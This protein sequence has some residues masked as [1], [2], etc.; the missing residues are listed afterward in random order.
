MDGRT[1]DL[2]TDCKAATSIRLLTVHIDKR[3]AFERDVRAFR[4]EHGDI[5]HVR[6]ATQKVLHD[7][8]IIHDDGMLFSGTSLSGLGLKQS[9]LVSLGEDLRSTSCVPRTTC[10]AK[11][12][13]CDTRPPATASRTS[14]T[15][16]APG[17]LIARLSHP[18]RATRGEP[19]QQRANK[20]PRTSPIDGERPAAQMIDYAHCTSAP[21]PEGSGGRSA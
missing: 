14:T 21:P 9:V 17:G 10:G 20:R 6:V 16:I 18:A 7:R 11:L 13:R 3:T 8:Y 2:L 4:K 12:R 5:L 1:L 19:G 15:G